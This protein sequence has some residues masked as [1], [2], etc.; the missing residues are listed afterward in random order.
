MRSRLGLEQESTI[1]PRRFQ[2]PDKAPA[3]DGPRVNEE[4]FS[5][6][7]LLIGDDGH[8]FGPIGLD[9]ARHGN[10]VE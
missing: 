7:I 2:Q 10:V 1:V 6:T 8:K 3:K 5:R 4:I 9:E